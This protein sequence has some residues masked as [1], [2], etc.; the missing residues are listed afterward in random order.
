MSSWEVLRTQLCLATLFGALSVGC[1]VS[2]GSAEGHACNEQ[3][4]CPAPFECVSGFCRTPTDST[5][6]GGSWTQAR[7][8]FTSTTTGTDCTAV[9]EPAAGN[10]LTATVLSDTGKDFAWGNATSGLPTGEEGRLG[11]WFA[12]P[13]TFQ[14]VSGTLSILRMV[15]QSGA[16]MLEVFLRPSD[17][18]VELY[19]APE[20]LDQALVGVG[21]TVGQNPTLAPLFAPGPTQLEVAWAR[22][23]FLKVYV[24][25]SLAVEYTLSPPTSGTISFPVRVQLGPSQYEGT[26]PSGGWR[27]I[28]SDWRVSEDPNASLTP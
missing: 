25:G 21:P 24:N 9:I 28:Y 23:Q 27:A 7:T 18:A 6:D 14:S 8:G 4:T 11:G 20:T 26:P 22:G 16:Q 2:L 15:D 10:R 1:T 5:L 12:M 19:A 17:A 13:D 3:H